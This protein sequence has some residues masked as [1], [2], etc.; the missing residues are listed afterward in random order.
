VASPAATATPTTQLAVAGWLAVRT[1]EHEL[2]VEAAQ[3]IKQLVRDRTAENQPRR[4]RVRLG[5]RVP[6][7]LEPPRLRPG[8][9]AL[10]RGQVTV[11]DACE[12]ARSIVAQL[13]GQVLFAKL[14]NDTQRL[15]VLWTNCLALLR[16]SNHYETGGAS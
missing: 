12:A 5:G 16:A 9:E 6:V 4:T 1:W 15:D 11:R 2:P 7:V 14:Y 8:T 3:A 10:E 13:E